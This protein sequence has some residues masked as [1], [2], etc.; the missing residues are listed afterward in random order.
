MVQC[1]ALCRVYTVLSSSLCCT[2]KPAHSY[3]QVIE[4][5]QFSSLHASNHCPIYNSTP[6]LPVLM[7]PLWL[8]GIFLKLFAWQGLTQRECTGV[9]CHV[10]ASCEPV[11]FRVAG[12]ATTDLRMIHSVRQVQP[13]FCCERL[14]CSYVL[15]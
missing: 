9:I 13:E 12:V 1:S 10:G 3:L 6:D 15:G 7:Q 11:Q 4:L 5:S 2:Y 8:Q 14:S